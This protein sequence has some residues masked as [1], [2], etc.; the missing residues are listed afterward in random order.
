MTPIEAS[1]PKKVVDVRENLYSPNSRLKQVDD[2]KDSTKKR[3]FSVGD[4]VKLSKHAMVF[5]RGY[6]PQWSIERLTI[7]EVLSTN[8]TE[9]NILVTHLKLVI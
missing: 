3:K 2:F 1:D 4:L 9:A 7:F 6:K 8:P 5:D